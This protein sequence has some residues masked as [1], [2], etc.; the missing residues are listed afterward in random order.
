MLIIIMVIYSKGNCNGN[1]RGNCNGSGS[2]SGSS[3]GNGNCNGI[4]NRMI[5][6]NFKYKYINK[7]LFG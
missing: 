6:S 3:K 5:C 7:Q 4:D 2:G 1:V